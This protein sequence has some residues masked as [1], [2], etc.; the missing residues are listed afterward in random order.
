MPSPGSSPASIIPYDYAATFRLRGIPGN[1]VE[2]VINISVESVFVA[3]AIGYGFEEERG[4]P[5][6]VFIP[7]EGF[8]NIPLEDIPPEALITGFRLDPRLGPTVLP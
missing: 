1:I 6:A 5:I 3:T 2:D 8:G 7:T 4:R